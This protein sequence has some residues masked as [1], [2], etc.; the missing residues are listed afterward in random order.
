MEIHLSFYRLLSNLMSFA[1]KLLLPTAMQAAHRQNRSL[2]WTTRTNPQKI[3]IL[4]L[5]LVLFVIWVGERILSEES[6]C[7]IPQRTSIL[8]HT[9]LS[10]YHK[11]VRSSLFEINSALSSFLSLAFLFGTKEETL[12]ALNGTCRQ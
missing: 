6:L 10:R 5:L 9:V 2:I 1:N 7:V 12:E 3:T 11:K 4:L 8:P